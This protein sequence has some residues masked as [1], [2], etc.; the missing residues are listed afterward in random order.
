[1]KI[2]VTKKQ[3]KALKNNALEK[4]QQNL[5]GVEYI[6]IDEISLLGKR[7]LKWLDQRLKQSKADEEQDKYFGKDL[8]QYIKKC[9]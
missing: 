5:A 8:F 2:P 1:M 6:V 4:L 7:T 9:R 3:R